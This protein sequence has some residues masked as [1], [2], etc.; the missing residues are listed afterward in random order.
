MLFLFLPSYPLFVNEQATLMLIHRQSRDILWFLYRVH[1]IVEFGRHRPKDLLYHARA[2]LKHFRHESSLLF[3]LLFRA[4]L[5]SNHWR[6]HLLSSL[7]SQILCVGLA[8]VLVWPS[9]ILQI[10]ALNPRYS[11]KYP[12]LVSSLRHF[13][14]SIETNSSWLSN[15]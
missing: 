3:F 14:Q 11:M 2:F 1:H 10:S 15:L 5:R 9:W 6:T 13:F 4:F 8:I 7:R 12:S